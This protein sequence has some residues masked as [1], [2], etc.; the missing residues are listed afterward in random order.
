MSNQ[1]P[2]IPKTINIDP[3]DR[4]LPGLWRGAIGELVPVPRADRNDVQSPGKSGPSGVARMRKSAR[5][6]N[7]LVTG[8]NSV[9]SREVVR[10]KMTR[11]P[12]QESGHLSPGKFPLVTEV[13]SNNFPFAIL[14]NRQHGSSRALMIIGAV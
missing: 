7:V 11:L 8:D 14:D 12:C 4:K 1:E 5:Q 3:F 6:K 2:L 13:L 10:Q 9:F